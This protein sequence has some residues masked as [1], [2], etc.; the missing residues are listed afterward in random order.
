MAVEIGVEV[1]EVE[2]HEGEE[3]ERKRRKKSH[4][5]PS[6]VIQRKIWSTKDG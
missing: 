6:R 5:Y 3:K 4:Q 1:V 2:V